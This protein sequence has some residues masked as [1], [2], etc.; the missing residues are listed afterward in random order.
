MKRTVLLTAALAAIIGAL[1]AGCASMVVV[2]V[3]SDSAQGPQRVRQYGDI[4]PKEII[5]YANYKDGSRKTLSVSKSDIS[6]DNS[7][8]GGQTVTVKTPKEPV[9]FQTEVM[10]LTG[11][12]VTPQPVL[13]KLGVPARVP[14]TAGA[15][16]P[17]STYAQAAPGNDQN[18]WPGL[19]IQGVWSQMSGEKLSASAIADECQFSGFDPNKAGTQ[20]VTVTWRGQRTTF[21]VN[22]VAMESMKITALP[23]KTTFYQGD[24]LDTRGL[25][26]TGNWPGIGEE[27]VGVQIAGYDMAKPGKQTLTVS[28]NGKTASFGIEVLVSPNGT[29]TRTLPETNLSKATVTEYR[30]AGGN[31]T[32]LVGNATMQRGTYTF[33]DST[34]TLTMTQI[35]LM[36]DPSK[37][38]T[39]QLRTKAEVLEIATKAATGWGD[40]P[41]AQVESIFAPRTFKWSVSGNTLTLT[42]DGL[43]PE[44]WTKK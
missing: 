34:I 19:G 42:Q 6:F 8:T 2:S 31:W 35:F 24:Q 3:E 14:K 39:A 4:D 23:A 29:W 17:G 5:I 13:R 28:A 7:K 40:N 11:L 25:K 12:T 44:K 20:A 26:V 21:N 27:E 38:E 37:P 32:F 22:V 36:T 10:A 16:L 18:N 43:Q 33:N 9:S 41:A 30:F 1:I 15:G